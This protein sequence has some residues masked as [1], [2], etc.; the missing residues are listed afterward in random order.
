M[1]FFYL[2][3]F[4]LAVPILQLRLNLL[5]TNLSYH[6]YA[7]LLFLFFL[8]RIYF[9]IVFLNLLIF[10]V[11]LYFLQPFTIIFSLFEL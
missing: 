11:L 8:D 5:S 2:F 3:K 4:L 10:L 1:L 7:F 9:F 6:F